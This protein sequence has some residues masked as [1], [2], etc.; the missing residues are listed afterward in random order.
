[1]RGWAIVSA[2]IL[3]ITL[4]AL[5]RYP[6]QAGLWG[7]SLWLA[8]MLVP[9]MSLAM[10]NH[11]AAKQNYQLAQ[12][13][14]AGL[15]LLHP[16]DGLWQYPQ[17]LRALALAQQ[18]K[19]KSAIAIL[20][21][22]AQG[23]GASYKSAK[24][25]TFRIKADWHKLHNWLA[26]EFPDP[27]KDSYLAAYH[28]RAWAEMGDLNALFETLD[29]FQHQPETAINPKDMLMIRLFGLAFGG[30]VEQLENMLS[31]RR[32][33]HLTGAAQQ[34]W[35]ATAAIATG[36]KELELKARHQL[37]QLAA[38]SDD[39][40]LK[41]A[42]EWRLSHQLANPKQVLTPANQR[43]L[44]ATS[45]EAAHDAKYSGALAFTSDRAYATY[46]LI[47]LNLAVFGLELAIG[48]STDLN[49][50]YQLGA[51][52]RS[53]VFQN[54][55][56]WR[57]LNATFLH[58]GSLHLIMNMFGLY[59]LGV[60]VETS[61]GLWR[62]LVV[63]FV[64][65]MGS[66]LI[67]TFLSGPEQLTVGASGAIMGMVGA[68]GAILWLA[69]RRERAKLAMQRLRTILFIIGFQIFFDLSTPNVSF[70]GHM[71]GLILGAIVGW[72]VA[73]RGSN[74]ISQRLGKN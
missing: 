19:F 10:V 65:G 30:E 59:F 72:L 67:V 58:Y 74:R 69:W 21:K 42:I 1:M 14:A 5:W 51:V 9:T 7:G 25:L 13:I 57:L 35:L 41:R 50:L 56:W 24:A 33:K 48:G 45:L 53:A 73:P 26:A 6:K 68:T 31:D 63:Y 28:A 66:M 22:Y 16:F 47:A 18:G 27:K 8:F 4:V 60:F 55:E 3:A 62:Y 52:E 43:I 64:S 61:L 23:D 12:F 17:L 70:V 32:L 37:E 44:Q 54:G 38:N 29:Y 34:F 11:L 15:R 49:K 46:A 71:S 2:I 36:K 39:A 40:I 20:K